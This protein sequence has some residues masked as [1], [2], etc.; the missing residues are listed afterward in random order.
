MDDFETESIFSREGIKKIQEDRT[1][2]IQVREKLN[3]VRADYRE[4]M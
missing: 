2:E 1:K 4:K 3:Q